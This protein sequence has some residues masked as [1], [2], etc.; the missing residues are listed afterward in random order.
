MLALRTFVLR[1]EAD[2]RNCSIFEVLAATV[3]GNAG[4][5]GCRVYRVQL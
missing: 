4:S 1:D 3:R 5:D 2:S